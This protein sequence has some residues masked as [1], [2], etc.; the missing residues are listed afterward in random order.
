MPGDYKCIG[1]LVEKV[2]QRDDGMQVCTCNLST[3]VA[4]WMEPDT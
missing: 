4:T 1:Q 3:I 2:N